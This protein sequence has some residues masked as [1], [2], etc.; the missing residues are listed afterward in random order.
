MGETI[1][2]PC[3]D[4]LL[5]HLPP[6]Q[7]SHPLCFPCWSLVNFVISFLPAN[8]ISE[9]DALPCESWR[10]PHDQMSCEDH[11]AAD[12]SVHTTE[13]TGWG[14]W[15]FWKH[16]PKLAA[17]VWFDWLKPRYSV[18]QLS[19]HGRA[20]ALAAPVQ[21]GWAETRGPL[22]NNKGVPGTARVSISAGERS[23][24]ADAIQM[25]EKSL[26]F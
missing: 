14:L 7:F 17:S 25:K 10:K 12:V 21:G 6:A 23:I 20:D 1:S 8:W 22:P 18:C 5:G 16:N 3:W 4:P 2:S 15:Q 19:S 11:A 26:M 13:N 24:L 9:L